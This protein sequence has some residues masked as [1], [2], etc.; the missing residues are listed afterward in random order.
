M[1]DKFNQYYSSQLKEI[2][3]SAILF[4]DN[5]GADKKFVFPYK[6]D[7]IKLDEI[8]TDN[9]FRIYYSKSNTIDWASLE[10]LL[11]NYFVF[12]QK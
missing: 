4:V 9:A 11:E 3:A 8:S 5:N 10:E 2:F 12:V 6:E 1:Q 7:Y